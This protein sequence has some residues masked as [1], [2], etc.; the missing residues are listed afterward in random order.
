[1]TIS[2]CHTNLVLG[3]TDKTHA[4]PLFVSSKESSHEVTRHDIEVHDNNMYA[5]R[6]S[7][8]FVCLFTMYCTLASKYLQLV[9]SRV[10]LP[11][12]FCNNRTKKRQRFLESK[13]TELGL[14]WARLRSTPVRFEQ[15]PSMCLQ[16]SRQSK[17]AAEANS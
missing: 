13:P 15:L 11:L 9:M 1:M 12:P 10:C 2:S 4:E 8:S 5:S 17:C 14:D 6:G 16:P 3:T 7:A